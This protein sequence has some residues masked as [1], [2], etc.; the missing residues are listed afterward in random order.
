MTGLVGGRKNWTVERIGV[1]ESG[2]INTFYVEHT[3]AVSVE[4]GNLWVYG[5]CS[6][7]A[8]IVRT[9]YPESTEIAWNVVNSH[10]KLPDGEY[11]ADN[12]E[13]QLDHSK[14]DS[15]VGIEDSKGNNA[16]DMSVALSCAIEAL[17][18]VSA[19]LIIA[20]AKLT[21]LE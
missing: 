16:R 8:I 14:L 7:G 13:N 2:F 4:H 21:A 18:D 10:E 17:K 12:Q 19:R 5:S 15:S 3:G 20:E 9:P 6:A 11:D 1:G